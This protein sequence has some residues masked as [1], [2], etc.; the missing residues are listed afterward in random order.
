M[1]C[2]EQTY[3]TR[4][5]SAALPCL[6][7]EQSLNPEAPRR[8]LQGL[9]HR[10]YKRGSQSRHSWTRLSFGGAGSP[11]HCRETAINKLINHYNRRF[12][13]LISKDIME[14]FMAETLKQLTVVGKR[15]NLTYNI[16]HKPGTNAAPATYSQHYQDNTY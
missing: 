3:H 8:H 10:P 14:H 6:G 11:S 15:Q 5:L 13:T 12:K 2:C 16:T 4:V 9:L 7:P 1:F